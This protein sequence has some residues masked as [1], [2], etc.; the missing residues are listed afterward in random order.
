[1]LLAVLL[2]GLFAYL[3]GWEILEGSW[4]LSPSSTAPV[5]ASVTKAPPNIAI[6]ELPILSLTVE[7]SIERSSW[8]NYR[9]R[10]ASLPRNELEPR[11]GAVLLA[12][13]T[14]D[15]TDFSSRL[16]GGGRVD[17]Q[18]DQPGQHRPVSRVRTLTT[19]V[20]EPFPIMAQPDSVA[21]A[22]ATSSLWPY[23]EVLLGQLEAL[24]GS[25]AA[26]HDQATV[27]WTTAVES[28]L[29]ELREPLPAA[30]PAEL[31]DRL[32]EK[33]LEAI[34]AV[35][36]G[37]ILEEIDQAKLRI[38][39]SLVR[40]LSV[41]KAV[42]ACLEGETTLASTPNFDVQQLRQSLTGVEHAVVA[43]GDEEGWESYLLM[44][45]LR[46]ILSGDPEALMLAG[47]TAQVVL[48]RITSVNVQAIQRRF[49]D[50]AAVH[51]LAEAL[52]PLAVGPV[53]YP[54]LLA[55]L[56]KVEQDAEH[57]GR[58][59]VIDAI[60]S[61]RFADDPRQIAISQ[62]LESYY[63]N[64]NVRLAVSQQ[65]INRLLPPHQRIQ[66]PVR[67]TILG[68]D[69]RGQSEVDTKLQ[70]GLV[71]DPDAWRVVLEL[72][73]EIQASTRSARGPATFFNSSSSK[74]ST[75][76][77]IRITPQGFEIDGGR[78]NVESQD[79]LRGLETDFDN[80][81]LVGDLVRYLA[82]KEFHDKRG[83]AKR[84]MQRTIAQQTDSEFDRQLDQ[85]LQQA[86]EKFERRLM[87]PLRNLQL[88]PVVT[89]LQ[90]TDDRLIARY[91]LANDHALAAN[92]P[93]PQAPADSLLSMQLH[94]S[95]FNNGF[96]R[97]GLSDREWTLL[98]L[99]QSL[100]HQF[101]QEP[102]ESLPEDVPTDVRLRFAGE[103]PVLVDFV[104]GRLW[105][106]LKLA[107]LTQPGRIELSDFVIRT[108]YVP[109]VSGL[110]AGLVREGVISVDGDRLGIRE[111]L[112]LRAIFAKVFGAHPYIPLVASS[113]RE[114]RRAEGLAISQ[115]VLE[116]GWLGL[117]I[118][119]QSSPHVALLESQQFHR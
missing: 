109:A 16:S 92:T 19:S 98:E 61:L 68:A 40:R 112:P 58:E 80:L 5:I 110:Q 8:L 108:S 111:R 93:R 113:L 81:P 47:Q 79:S 25:S 11:A 69:T 86:E 26:I 106:T 76:R 59:T 63:R 50:S 14:S 42:W 53:N 102:I 15:P 43:T 41:W 91:R 119:E 52:H 67:Q 33:S 99:A 88:N 104:D 83:P 4:F 48:M 116:D 62:A 77:E 66:R 55:D 46:T 31:L 84:I 51:H 20:S 78:A 39:H 44:P 82:E 60:Q 23:P 29:A 114:D 1:M 17:D 2:T 73:G 89:D 64:A 101:G 74:V 12:P 105:L 38:A 100:A 54:R 13:Q 32:Q 57:R 70:V 71:P 96:S 117:A 24:R 37:A 49:L 3:Q 36:E 90:T 87:G 27:G 72:Q 107:L 75:S 115:I 118:S 56:E 94:E 6:D 103:R 85:Q 45:E 35:A 30:P 28:L 9:T 65:L 18:A 7:G 97:L 10:V 22:T 21:E 34:H 95:A